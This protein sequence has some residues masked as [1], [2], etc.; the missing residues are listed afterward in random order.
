[1]NSLSHKRTLPGGGGG[2]GASHGGERD[3]LVQGIGGKIG[4]EVR[5]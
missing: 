5:S 2:G 4:R 3:R 1:L